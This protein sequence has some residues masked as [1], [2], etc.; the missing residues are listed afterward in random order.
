MGA[1]WGG[2]A[3]AATTG[4]IA[5]AFSGAVGGALNGQNVFQSA[6]IGAGYGALSGAVLGGI[7]KFGGKDWNWKVGLGRVGLSVVAGGGISELAGGSFADGAMFAGIV[8]GSDFVYR[9][10]VSTR[11]QGKNVGASMK[12]ASESGQPKLGADGKPLTVDNKPVVLNKPQQSNVGNPESAGAHG[13]GH[14]VAGETGPVMNSLGKNVPGF[15]GLSLAHD[16]TGYNLT[17]TGLWG[18]MN[19][20]TM[21]VIYGINAAGSMIND[22]PGMIGFYENYRE[23]E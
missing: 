19:F 4:A 20:P 9:S 15:Q 7:S 23:K 11:P 12:T 6:L 2:I 17:G 18:L 1:F 13:L 10:I 14:F 21:P 16:I 8:A 5:G 22:S 3:S